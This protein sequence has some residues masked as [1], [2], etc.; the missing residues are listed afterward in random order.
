MLKLYGCFVVTT[1]DG[2]V[3]MEGTGAFVG[4]LN[5]GFVCV[6]IFLVGLKVEAGKVKGCFGVVYA[7]P[8]L[9]FGTT[10]FL[11]VVLVCGGLLSVNGFC[12]IG[13]DWDEDGK[14][15]EAVGRVC[16]GLLSVNGF[17]G[18]GDDWDEDGKVGETVGRIFFVG[19]DENDG[20]RTFGGD[21]TTVGGLVD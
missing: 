8:V 11:F 12:G 16:G 10:V 17:C 19:D 3:G 4:K 1:E 5:D 21:V 14:V 15:G 18:I 20:G 13:D 2:R 6:G 9:S 7:Y